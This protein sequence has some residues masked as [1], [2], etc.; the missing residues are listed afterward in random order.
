MIE[1]G[2]RIV[3]GVSGGKDS[4]TLL[5][6]LLHR[7]TI[8]PVDFDIMAMHVDNGLP[9]PDLEKLEAHFRSLDVPYHIERTE[10]FRDQAIKELNCFWCS[11][12][13]RKALFKF[14]NES[15]FR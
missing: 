6:V 9:G 14:A 13:R 10:T 15:G 7:R 2:D 5:S 8:A 3:V 12:N 11:W 1:N 4:L